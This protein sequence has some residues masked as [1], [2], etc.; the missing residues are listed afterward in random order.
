MKVYQRYQS[1]LTDSETYDVEG[2]MWAAREILA[3]SSNDSA[4][5]GG[6]EGVEVLTVDGFTDFTPTQLE[7]LRLLSRSLQ[8][9]VITLPYAQDSRE[10]LWRWSD[11]TLRRI[12]DAFG[13]DLEEIEASPLESRLR[14]VWDRVFDLDLDFDAASSTS[15]AGLSVIAAC[16]AEAE[17]ATVARRIK[18][19]LVEDTST[20]RIA[21]LARSM[22]MYRPAIERIFTEH[23]IPLVP[24]PQP[25]SEIPIV[26]F[27][28]DAAQIA[29]EFAF[30]DVLGVINSSYFRPQALGPYGRAELDAA[31]MLIREGNVLSG[32][33]AY[34]Q[35]GK[36]LV[37]RASG[38]TDAGEE[39]FDVGPLRPSADVLT[40]GSE[41]LQRLFDLAGSATDAQGLLKLIDALELRESVLL[42][43]EDELIARDL[44]ALSQLEALLA[45]PVA[46]NCSLRHFREALGAIKCPSGAGESLVDVCDVL[47]ARAVRCDHVFLVGL[48]EGVFPRRYVESSLISESD[49]RRWRS[50]G[51][52]LDARGDLTAREMLLL[53]LAISRTNESLT[54]SFVEGDN[55]GARG[56]PSAFLLS[57]L[58]PFGG[59]EAADQNDLLERIGVGK[60]VPPP[61]EIATS[62]DA[63]NSALTGFFDPESVDHSASL[64]WAVKNAP[65]KIPRS[66]RGIFTRFRRYAPGACDS[67]DGLITD[68][69]LLD[70]LR[71]RFGGETIFS[72]TQLN[73]YGQCPWSFFAGY[74][75]KLDELREP[76]RCLEPIQRGLFVHRVL[77][78]LMSNLHQESEGAFKLANVDQDRLLAALRAAIETESARFRTRRPGYSALWEVQKER[79]HRQLREYLLSQRSGVS[80]SEHLYFELAFGLDEAEAGKVDPASRCEPVELQTPAGAVRVRGKIDRADRVNSGDDAGLLVIDYKT[81]RI[82]THADINAG[83]NLQLAI[84]TEAIEQITD[85]K[86]LGG[87]FHQVERNEE[88]HFSLMKPPRREKRPFEQRRRDALSRIGEFVE[89]MRAGRFDALPE[90]DC[91]GYCPFRRIC[92]Y[93]PARARIKTPRSKTEEGRT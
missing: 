74:I 4:P 29:P 71:G 50:G 45:D 40:A 93:S 68:P 21:V 1:A 16:S 86:A 63:F 84:Y 44:R 20:P 12:R 78:S 22:E 41:M 19:I 25:A 57:I 32:R 23:D 61:D 28:F 87:V 85:Q 7:I 92:H 72:A 15:P 55:S 67:F 24:G 58:E 34:E 5:P 42:T 77:F 56:A 51:I 30:R 47:D 13:E 60:F 49:R 3:Q 82:P 48:S 75:L 70:H 81:G 9:V 83:R 26:R 38:P 53:Y 52:E 6:L 59:I 62:R 10:R 80:N 46:T 27:V 89:Q 73:T 65:E 91:P 69:A 18:R 11:R 43:G 90:H 17:I 37:R 8:R 39:E 66:A 64:A 31:Q 14:D 79:I 76:G 88:L 54:V 2:L 36:R 35:A 33:E